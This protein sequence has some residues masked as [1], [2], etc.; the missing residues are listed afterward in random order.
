MDV[1]QVEGWAE[2]AEED[3]WGADQD[4]QGG[5]HDG[6]LQEGPETFLILNKMLLSTSVAD[7]WHFCVDPD[8]RIHASD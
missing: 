3:V 7:P 6:P 2:E 5:V 4:Q 8:P 1:L